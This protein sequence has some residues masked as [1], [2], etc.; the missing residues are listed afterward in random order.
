MAK[1]RFL[2]LDSS[3]RIC[4]GKFVEKDVTDVEITAEGDKLVIRPV[5]QMI[6]VSGKV[7]NPD[8]G[9]ED[10]LAA[11]WPLDENGVS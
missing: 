8:K 3:R 10:P 5:R 11:I 7:R 4:I 6:G 2:H 9:I 1:T